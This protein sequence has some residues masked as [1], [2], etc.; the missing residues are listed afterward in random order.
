MTECTALFQT[1]FAC[2]ILILLFSGFVNIILSGRL[3]RT[4]CKLCSA[5]HK[6]LHAV[7][8]P[9]PSASVSDDQESID[10]NYTVLQFPL[11]NTNPESSENEEREERGKRT[12]YSS[13][14]CQISN[15]TEEN[16]G[17]NSTVQI[18]IKIIEDH[19]TDPELINIYK[20][21]S[22]PHI[23]CRGYDEDDLRG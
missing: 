22:S 16:W 8:A 3:R 13:L 15:I 2:N 1:V 7:S 6:N 9:Q 10:V 21:W 14:K 12:I 17:K 19:H 11:E 18:S 5:H 23:R 4:K 20:L